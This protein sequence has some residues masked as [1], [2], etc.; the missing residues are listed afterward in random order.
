M[1]GWRVGRVVVSWVVGLVAFSSVWSGIFPEWPDFQKDPTL[2]G[3][4]LRIWEGLPA[5][6]AVAS[7]RLAPRNGLARLYA[8][9]IFFW[10]RSNDLNGIDRLR[11]RLRRLVLN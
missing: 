8:R 5:V 9:T 2:P 7:K 4:V 10:R 1:S 3:R 11:L 6:V